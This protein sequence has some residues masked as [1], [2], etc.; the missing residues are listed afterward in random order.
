ML[1]ADCTAHET[2]QYQAEPPFDFPIW[3][4]AGFGDELVTRERLDAW[5]RTHHRHVSG[6]HAARWASV[7]GCNA[8][9]VA[10]VDGAAFV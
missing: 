6:A 2:Y 3:V 4:Y 5:A 9:H 10:A 8:R 7:R 1:R